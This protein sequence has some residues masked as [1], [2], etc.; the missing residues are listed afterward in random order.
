MEELTNG[1]GPKENRKQMSNQQIAAVFVQQKKD[2][3]LYDSE[4]AS[5]W[6]YEENSW[7]PYSQDEMREAVATLIWSLNPTNGM[8]EGKQD[9]IIK[10]IRQYVGPRSVFN[11][12]DENGK[13]IRYGH[14]IH[15]VEEKG[16]AFNDKVL[17]FETMD[18]VELSNSLDRLSLVSLDF[19]YSD[20]ENASGKV[21]MR[22]LNETCT[23]PDGT[24]NEGM[25]CQLQE[26][27]GFVLSN[28]KKEKCLI[29]KGRGSNGKSP[30]LNILR[31]MVGPTRHSAI[32]LDKL[33]KD[34]FSVARLVGVKLNAKGEE[35][36]KAVNLSLLKEIISGE[37]LEA[38]RKGKDGFTF[39]PR[40]RMCFSTN[41]PPILKGMGF[42]ELRRILIIPFQHTVAEKD[43]D[44]G[45]TDKLKKEMPFIV[46]WSLEGLRR[47]KENNYV[48]T[49]TPESENELLELEH[50]N[51]SVAEYFE[52]AW[53]VDSTYNT[54]IKDCFDGFSM[55]AR[56][57]N[58][59][60]VSSNT[61]GRR[62]SEKAGENY[63]FKKDG[64]TVRCWHVRPKSI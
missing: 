45:L 64:K 59:E 61:F 27:A 53:E 18:T 17:L 4:T 46:K 55:F 1:T 43:C 38:E 3:L 35:Q 8:T 57:N 5:F 21:F 51:N 44:E 52:G 24:L 16:I 47:L 6:L 14:K 23:R 60:E 12:R 22:Y 31:Y 41:D 28:S 7:R 56:A 11:F 50:S 20:I 29:L 36:G 39:C 34:K 48:F 32:S 49:S 13:P 2:D 62:F 10:Q 26:W 19:D 58:R 54:P 40:C 63:P 33:S 30:Y 9:D 42:A 15:G 25:V 37:P